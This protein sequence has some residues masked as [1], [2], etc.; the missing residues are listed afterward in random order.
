[1]EAMHSN[2]SRGS[3]DSD[4]IDSNP[5]MHY[6]VESGP[7]RLSYTLSATSLHTKYTHST[8]QASSDVHACLP[9]P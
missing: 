6:N 8:P 9:R 5:S 4:Q 7:H 2:A 3:E 1:M